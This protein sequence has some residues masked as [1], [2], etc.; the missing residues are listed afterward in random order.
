MQPQVRK[1]DRRTAE[2]IRITGIW[3]ICTFI[4]CFVWKPPIVN[5]SSVVKVKLISSS[6]TRLCYDNIYI[7][8]TAILTLLQQFPLQ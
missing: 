2:S 8:K 1:Q 4:S 3:T 7:N 6:L 5:I